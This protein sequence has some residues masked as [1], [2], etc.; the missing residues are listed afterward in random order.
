MVFH[1]LSDK[2][3]QEKFGENLKTIRTSKGLTFAQLAFDSDIEL[4]QVHRVEKGKAHFNHPNC[5]S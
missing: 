1:N 2:A 3:T 5:F 4:S